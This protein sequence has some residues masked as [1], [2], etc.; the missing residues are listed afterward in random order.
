MSEDTL[1]LLCTKYYW[2]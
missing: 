2:N 1:F